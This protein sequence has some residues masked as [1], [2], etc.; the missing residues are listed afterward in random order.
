MLEIA[1]GGGGRGA[2]TRTH[3]ILVKERLAAA[4]SDTCLKILFKWF[5]SF[6]GHRK[7]LADFAVCDN[8]DIQYIWL[9]SICDASFRQIEGNGR[10]FFS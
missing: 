9:Y 2:G 6:P 1:G 7:V 10:N 3:V 5:P 8:D 4:L